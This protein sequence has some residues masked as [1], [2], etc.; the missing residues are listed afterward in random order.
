[1][2]LLM[3][4]K[5]MH[6]ISPWTFAFISIRFGRLSIKLENALVYLGWP[7]LHNSHGNAKYDSAKV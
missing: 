3:S 6:F 5:L 7:H 4:K 1:M 2:N